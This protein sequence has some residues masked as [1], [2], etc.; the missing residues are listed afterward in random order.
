M[1]RRAWLV[2]GCAALY[3]ALGC[4][5]DQTN[6]DSGTNDSSTNDGP[7]PTEGGPTD[8]GKDTTPPL[9]AGPGVCSQSATWGANQAVSVSTAQA[10][11]LGAVTGDELTIAWMTAQGAVLYAD[12]TSTSSAFGAPQTLSGAIALDQV[13]L[14]AD[15]LTMIVVSQDRSSL[16]QTTRSSRS[17]AFSTTLDTTPFAQLDPPPTEGDSGTSQGL[18]ADPVLSS[19]G[20]LL[21]YSQTGVNVYTMHESYRPGASGA[22]P[23]GRVLI[24]QALVATSLSARRRPSGLSAD[25][26]TLFF[27]DES[28][29]IERTAFRDSVQMPN[30]TYKTFVDLGAY[31]NAEP[32]SSCTRIDFSA[33]G[34][35][36]LD[37]FYA[38][39]Q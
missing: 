26:R 12:R 1:R 21:Y 23:Q 17:A 27:W 9:D 38:D 24:E 16:A 4:S 37:L 13:A 5:E 3:A 6:Q 18:F 28:T 25:G 33:S 31:E 30:N 34:S 10:D 20:Q 35:G 22:W 14:S 2:V 11:L 7:I 8:S 32:T 36:G 15:G 39:K 29:N 19:D